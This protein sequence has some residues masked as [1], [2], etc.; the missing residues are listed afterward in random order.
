[1]ATNTT[2]SGG[3]L[4]GNVLLY[5]NPEPLNPEN[6]K[7]LG[8]ST[9]EKPFMFASIAHAVPLSVTEFGPAS[10]RF[11]IIF[12]GDEYQPV[13]IMSIRQDENLFLMDNGYF[14][15]DIYVPAFIRRYPFVLAK[16]QGSDR[17]I[18]CVDR[19]AEAVQ[20]NGEIPLFVGNEPSEF[21]RNA[22]EFCTNF[23]NERVRTALFTDEL[24]RLDLFELKTANFT[25]MNPDGSQGE[26]MKIAEYYGISEEK[27]GALSAEDLV[28]LRDSGA[29]QQIYAHLSSLQNW[30]RLINRTLLKDGAAQAAEQAANA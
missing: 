2:T 1:M 24:K 5:K 8:L 26:M 12:T 30:E 14:E 25:P 16:E 10:M 29:L 18:V 6:M 11:P 28:A 4:S 27:L 19:G 20:E 13:A 7:T 22:I 21:A 3:E 17:L 15:M 23:E 9:I